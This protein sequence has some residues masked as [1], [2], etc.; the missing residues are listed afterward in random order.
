MLCTVGVNRVAVLPGF[1][2]QGQE[3]FLE[4][5]LFVFRAERS[6]PKEGG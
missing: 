1:G 6:E 3:G 5:V 4:K 2:W